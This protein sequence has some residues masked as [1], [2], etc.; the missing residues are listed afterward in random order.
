MVPNPTIANTAYAATNVGAA[1]R[2][3]S[4]SGIGGKNKRN[5]RVYLGRISGCGADLRLHCS[6]S[7]MSVCDDL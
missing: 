4:N 3:T 7:R 6:N 5:G 2:R 1:M